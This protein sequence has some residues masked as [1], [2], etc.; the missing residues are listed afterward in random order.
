[1]G[2]PDSGSPLW[3][4]LGFLSEP[5]P[6]A[7]RVHL[8]DGAVNTPGASLQA[9][10]HSRGCHSLKLLHQP[11]EHPLTFTLPARCGL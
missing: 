6:E 4:A 3:S 8:R 5:L 7:S 9:A 10:A 2:L 1:M 11:Q